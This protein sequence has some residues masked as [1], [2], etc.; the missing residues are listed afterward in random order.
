MVG[1]GTIPQICAVWQMMHLTPKVRLFGVSNPQTQ[2]RLIFFAENNG[3]I[4]LLD[5]GR[6]E[7]KWFNLSSSSEV[8]FMNMIELISELHTSSHARCLQ[9]QLNKYGVDFQNEF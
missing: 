8:L 6:V 5:Y 9:I 4:L 1:G 7:P 2:S 3:F